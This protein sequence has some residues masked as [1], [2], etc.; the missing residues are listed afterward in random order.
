MCMQQLIVMVM[1]VEKRGSRSACDAW[2]WVVVI[3]ERGECVEGG[4]CAGGLVAV[5]GAVLRGKE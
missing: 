1:G 4:L 2:A 5:L 3:D